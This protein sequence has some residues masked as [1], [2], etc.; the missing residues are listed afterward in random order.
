MTLFTNIQEDSKV[1]I[2]I[3]KKEDSPMA[4][5]LYEAAADL[6]YIRLF[7]LS[8]KEALIK[9][10][11]HELDSVFVIDSGFAEKIKSGARNR[12][13][14]GYSNHGSF[15]YTPIKEMLVSYVQTLTAQAKTYYTVNQMAGGKWTWEEVT[16]KISDIQTEQQLLETTFRFG[17]MAGN[18]TNEERN[19]N[20]WEIWGYFMFISIF[21]LFDWQ[22]KEKKPAILSRYAMMKY[23][24]R[25]YVFFHTAVYTFMF[26]SICLLSAAMFHMLYEEKITFSLLW[27][28]VMYTI[29]LSLAASIL[30]AVYRSVYVYYWT[31][32]LISGVYLITSGVIIPTDGI[33]SAYPVISLVHPVYP[34]V[35]EKYF[36]PLVILFL[37]LFLVTQR[38]QKYF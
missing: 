2:A 26:I 38:K 29:T 22:I 17:S 1:P 16:E 36:H 5:S 12:L 9:L 33:V 10:E 28:M 27:S 13:I 35:Q 4:D 25:Q 14:T 15:A 8:E 32:L 34:L 37:G 18:A 3:V 31:V 11:R 30:S 20:L 7:N 23:S 19:R 6:P 24:Y 21:F